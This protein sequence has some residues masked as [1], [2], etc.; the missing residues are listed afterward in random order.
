MKVVLG[1]LLA[2]LLAVAAAAYWVA[3]NYTVVAARHGDEWMVL[4]RERERAC[5]EQGGCSV[6]SVAETAAMVMLLLQRHQQ[7]Q[8]PQS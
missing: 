6:L 1:F 8:G 3:A 5:I 2:L 7:R 4:T